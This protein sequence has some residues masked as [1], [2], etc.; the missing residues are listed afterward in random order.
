MPRLRKTRS[1]YDLI[2]DT[3]N[4]RPLYLRFDRKRPGG[5]QIGVQ[6]LSAV[7][8][9]SPG[10]ALEEWH[11]QNG[12]GGAGTTIET[13]QSN[14]EGACDHGE[15]VWLRR[16]GVAQSSG[17]LTE[18][19]L[20]ALGTGTT[21]GLLW[22]GQVFDGDLYITTNTR[23]LL[24][25]TGATG[26]S[27]V[28]E[29]DFGS[30]SHTTG[31][32]VFK[33]EGAS[34]A[35]LY[36]GDTSGGIQV[37]DGSSWTE[38]AAGTERGF[39]DVP[40][41]TLG[42][43][44][45]TGGASSDA[46]GSGY[47]LVGTNPAGTGIYHVS[48]D[49]KVAANWSA[50][51]PVGTGGSFFPI[52]SSIATN[53]EVYYGTG[54]GV[55]GIDGLGYSPNFTKWVELNAD[56]NFNGVWATYWAGLIWFTTTQGLA[57]FEPNG[58]RGDIAKTFRFGA[59]SGM[60]EQY[61][62]MQ[63]MAPSEDGLWCGM[64]N[65]ITSI[66]YIGMLIL[67]ADGSYR[68]SMAEA[69]IR[70]E[71]VTF[72]QQAT[73]V[74]GNPRLFIGTIEP[75]TR[76]MHLYVQSLPRSGDPE[77]DAITGGPFVASENWSVTLSRFNG[78]RPVSKILRRFDL[79]ADYLGSSYPGNA[80]EFQIAADGGTPAV[81]GT[82][83]TSPRWTGAPT[84][85][86]V[87]A[88]NVQPK[89]VVR[90]ASSHPVVIHTATVRYTPRP[91]RTKVKTYPVII[92]EGASG[93]DPRTVLTRLERMLRSGPLSTT[94]ELGRTGDRII[95]DVQEKYVEEADGKG[96]TVHADVLVSTTSEPA[97]FDAGDTFDSG[98]TFS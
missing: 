97:R 19:S 11:W 91:E 87:Q 48:G 58:E 32:A 26:A 74:S 12:P 85:G 63:V 62:Y 31:I 57:A 53:H 24:K 72:L 89:L 70:G 10:V 64:Y 38:G 84:S 71:A 79:E 45:A 7:S 90:N 36:V 52:R 39:L 60:S 46:G 55:F 43:Q 68:W 75:D 54:L 37:Y 17:A 3:T 34:D 4:A 56:T 92:G 41:W 83:S 86:Y 96:Y 21:P 35:A 81:Q 1:Q 76:L 49:P 23:Y 94:D 22:R 95:E 6:H 8:G 20:A 14:G 40:Y 27:G 44:L 65:P 47:R 30:G 16:L 51:T 78:G 69:V 5:F 50:L 15:F 82:A 66:S 88:T 2:L 28:T 80:V 42:D 29:V 33:Y 98:E 59:A 67:N 18:V 73:D 9:G 61:G 13:P 93:Q 25:V 77:A